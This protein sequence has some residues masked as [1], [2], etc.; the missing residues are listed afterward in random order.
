MSHPALPSSTVPPV[1]TPQVSP[2]RISVHQFPPLALDNIYCMYLQPLLP[3]WVAGHSSCPQSEDAAQCL[4]SPC[5]TGGAPHTLP[6]LLPLTAGCQHW[7]NPKLPPL[8]MRGHHRPALGVAGDK[9][10]VVRHV[11]GHLTNISSCNRTQFSPRM[12]L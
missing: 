4:T 12:I 7:Q 3:W 9:H 6:Q 2:T 8:S 1:G 10:P 5:V 11:T